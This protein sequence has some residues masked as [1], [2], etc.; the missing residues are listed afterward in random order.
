MSRRRPHRRRPG[1]EGNISS[2]ISL[3]VGHRRSKTKYQEVR[4]AGP[5][6]AG[7]FQRAV[8][9]QVRNHPN[10]P[11]IVAVNG[12]QPWLGE[13]LHTCIEDHWTEIADLDRAVQYAQTMQFPE[14]ASKRGRWVPWTFIIDQSEGKSPTHLSKHC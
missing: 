6:D 4:V 2:P 10:D 14:K 12:Y 1:L 3:R 11:L 13:I 8:Q 7:S 9:E 5:E